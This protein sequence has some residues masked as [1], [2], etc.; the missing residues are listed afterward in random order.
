MASAPV[1]AFVTAE[2][3]ARHLRICTYL[4]SLLAHL[5]VTMLRTSAPDRCTHMMVSWLLSLFYLPASSPFAAPFPGTVDAC[6]DCPL[7]PLV[8]FISSTFEDGLTKL[9][10]PLIWKLMVYMRGSCL[11]RFACSMPAGHALWRLWIPPLIHFLPSQSRARWATRRQRL[12]AV[13]DTSRKGEGHIVVVA[14]TMLAASDE[15]LM[16]LAS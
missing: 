16:R 11:P 9:S 1:P 10:S 13:L 3:R 7:L 8:P 15:R 14:A 6:R 2:S 4:S 12:S 5:V